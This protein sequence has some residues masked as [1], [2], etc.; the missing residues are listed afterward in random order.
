MT[1][2]SEIVTLVLKM[3]VAQY[4]THSFW[5]WEP[6]SKVKRRME[7]LQETIS[8]QLSS[9][10]RSNST[11]LFIFFCILASISL[12][13]NRSSNS[14]ATKYKLSL[15]A[16]GPHQRIHIG[17]GAKICF[18]NRL[19]QI[20]DYKCKVQM[21]YNLQDGIRGVQE[22]KEAPKLRS[23]IAILVLNMLGTC[24]L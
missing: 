17:V 11:V 8:I 18:L 2:W 19:Q 9:T 23:D 20:I 15:V 22:A 21:P 1:S 24:F 7:G 6:L 14:A 12:Y 3:L 10:Q 5:N 4:Q 13:D 16:L